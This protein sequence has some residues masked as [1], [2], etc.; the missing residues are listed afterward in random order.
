MEA[1]SAL[2]AGLRDAGVRLEEIELIIITHHHLDHSGLAATIA[3]RSGA[4]V[5]A[6]DRAAA[7]GE[8]YAGDLR[9]IAGFSRA[10]APPG[11]TAAV[12]EGNEGFWG[13]IRRTSEAWYTGRLLAD[14]D[15]IRAGNRE[16]RVVARPATAP[17]TR[18]SSMIATSSR[19]SATTCSPRCRRTPKVY[20]AVEPDGTARGLAWSTSRASA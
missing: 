17:L 18:C 15:R 10:D 20:L 9:P 13:Y 7:Y 19:S 11:V 16:L 2:K 12:V 1:L 8:R 14:G 6:L 4:T 5:A 3:A